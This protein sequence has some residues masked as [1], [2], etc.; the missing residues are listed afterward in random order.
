MGSECML[1]AWSASAGV[2]MCLD[3]NTRGGVKLVLMTDSAL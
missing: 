2:I 3:G 1:M